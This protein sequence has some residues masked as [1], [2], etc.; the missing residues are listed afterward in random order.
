MDW[1]AV[2]GLITIAVCGLSWASG[3]CVTQK[4][5][6]LMLFSWM[7]ANIIHAAFN[8]PSSLVANAALDLLGLTIIAAVIFPRQKL[9]PLLAF[10]LVSYMTMITAHL[11]VWFSGSRNF[12]GYDLFLNMVFLS[13]LLVTGGGAIVQIIGRLRSH[14]DRG[15]FRGSNHSVAGGKR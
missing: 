10:F 4:I 1:G 7:A 15:L 2:Y 14:P 9:S 13:Q 5:A 11:S 6:L 3:R 12:G 8:P